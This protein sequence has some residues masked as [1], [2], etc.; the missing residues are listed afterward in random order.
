M[1]PQPSSQRDSNLDILKAI[2]IT[3][4]LLWHFQ[5]LQ[6]VL[7][8]H[9]LLS[10]IS[11]ILGE[12]L[13]YQV[14]L[15]AVPLLFT[16]SLHLYF[17]KVNNT[18]KYLSKRV[19][20]LLRLL[21]FW[22]S[23]QFIFYALTLW[24][25]IPDPH[26]ATTKSLSSL[27]SIV[28][29]L[30]GI[31]PQ[32][33]FVGDSVFYF[34]VNLIIVTSIGTLY[35][36]IPPQIRGRVGIGLIALSTIYFELLASLNLKTPYCFPD[37]FLIYIVVADL[38]THQRQ[39]LNKFKY[40]YLFLYLGFSAQDLILRTS[41]DILSIYA[42]ASILFGCLTVL[43]FI[44]PMRMK[45]PKFASNLSKYS[46]GIFAI[47]K[48]SQYVFSLMLYTF[49]AKIKLGTIELPLEPMLV[50]VLA[51]M[52]TSYVIFL[53]RSTPLSKFVC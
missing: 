7:N 12:G 16:I 32:L 17:K 15:M 30:I 49:D 34:L 33:P 29:I 4:V 14:F 43:T 39:Q 40:L 27:E 2:C 5:P 10:Q 31:G 9:D 53:V 42:R 51:L 35:M 11:L 25:N 46:L 36:R 22:S 38:F 28:K 6:P 41:D 37:S 18:A 50:S 45:I 19:K 3:F 48:Y 21:L 47:H 24:I 52:L 8:G 1:P 20:S 13:K 23:V 26:S 44:Y